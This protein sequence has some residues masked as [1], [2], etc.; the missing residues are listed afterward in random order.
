[1][2]TLDAVLNDDCLELVLVHAV[3]NCRLQMLFQE[4]ISNSLS[5]VLAFFCWPFL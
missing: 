2:G 3:E 5:L 1:M 4:K